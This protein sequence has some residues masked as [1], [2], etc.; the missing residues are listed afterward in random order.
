MSDF[1]SESYGSKQERE[2]KAAAAWERFVKLW[3]DAKLAGGKPPATKPRD[4]M[5][6]QVGRPLEEFIAAVDT[7]A[8]RIEALARERKYVVAMAERDQLKKALDD[9]DQARLAEI[10]AVNER[11]AAEVAPKAQRIGAIDG[12]AEQH[13]K[14]ETLVKRTAPA[15]SD[16][17]EQ[18]IAEA[19]ARLAAAREALRQAKDAAVTAQKQAATLRG[20]GLPNQANPLGVPQKIKEADEEEQKWQRSRALLPD[21]QKE[22]DQRQQELA[23]L[24]E[25]V[26]LT[27]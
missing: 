9:A 25:E 27:P 20:A 19:E 10:A 1:W 6:E 7:R 23:A 16:E 4:E 12:M 21:L 2:A 11:W 13:R 24:R 14:D 15:P 17:T 8:L 22:H 5:L 3:A 18:K 26:L